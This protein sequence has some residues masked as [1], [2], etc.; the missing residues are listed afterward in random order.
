VRLRHFS[1][2]NSFSRYR[3]AYHLPLLTFY[4]AWFALDDQGVCCK[5]ISMAFRMN[6][7][8]VFNSLDDADDSERLERWNMSPDERLEILERLKSLKYPDGKNAPRLR[9]VLEVASQA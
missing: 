9:R 4:P 2:K 3:F 1:I 5:L 8:Q 6:S 7:I